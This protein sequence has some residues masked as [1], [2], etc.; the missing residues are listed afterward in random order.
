MSKKAFVIWG[1][2]IIQLYVTVRIILLYLVFSKIIDVTHPV[3]SPALNYWPVIAFGIILY[4]RSKTVVHQKRFLA[5]SVP[6]YLIFTMVGVGLVYLYV[7]KV[8]MESDAVIRFH[9]AIGDWARNGTGTEMSWTLEQKLDN[10]LALTPI[11]YLGNLGL[12]ALLWFG[13]LDPNTP[14]QNQIIQRLKGAL[15]REAKEKMGTDR[16]SLITH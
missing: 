8:Y 11:I 9:G 13:S 10:I 3:F 2:V 14:S 12:F 6:I 15:M 7:T 5:L 4:F 1:L 16:K